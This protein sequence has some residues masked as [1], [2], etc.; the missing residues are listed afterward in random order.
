[1]VYV[2]VLVLI[3]CLIN[4]DVVYSKVFAVL[5]RLK[6]HLFE[7]EHLHDRRA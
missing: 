4:V 6:E 2:E 3:H 7:E 1:M 5:L